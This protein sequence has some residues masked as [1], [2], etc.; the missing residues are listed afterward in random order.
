MQKKGVL[1]L[2]NRSV[3]GPF[4]SWPLASKP[5]GGSFIHSSSRNHLANDSAKAPG[6]RT[7]HMPLWKFRPVRIQIAIVSSVRHFLVAILRLDHT[8]GDCIPTSSA[9]S[10]IPLA[11]LVDPA[12]CP[13]CQRSWI[14]EDPG[15]GR[16]SCQASVLPETLGY[17]GPGRDR[18]EETRNRLRVGEFRPHVQKPPSYPTVRPPSFHPMGTSKPMPSTIRAPSSSCVNINASQRSHRLSTPKP[19]V[20][21]NRC[22]SP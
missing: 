12:G 3:F 14:S 8:T 7:F 18:I 11:R 4:L 15:R 19:Q 2:R 17:G 13:A 1:M 9:S 16:V 6:E 22:L 20:H 21:L 10:K 5:G